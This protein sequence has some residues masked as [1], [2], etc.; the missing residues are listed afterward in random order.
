MAKNDDAS[1]E[2]MRKDVEYMMKDIKYIWEQLEKSNDRY[3]NEFQ[4]VYTQIE[5]H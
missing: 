5:D 4:R 3:T 1:L 2:G